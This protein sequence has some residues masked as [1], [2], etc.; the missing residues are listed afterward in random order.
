MT[1][2][3]TLLKNDMRL[4]LKDWKALIL[5]LVM[6]FLFINLF[7]YALSPYL[8]N[9]RFIEPFE[10]ALADNEDTAQTRI[11]ARQLEEIG[12]FK[13]IRRVSEDEA[14][15]LVGKGEVAAAIIIPPEFTH[16]IAVGENKPVTVLGSKAMPL[17]SHVV[18]NLVQSAANLVSAG[19]SAINAIYYYNSKAGLDRKELDREFS[20]STSKFFLEMLSRNEM[21]SHIEG[22]PGFDA[23]PAEYFTAALITVFLMFSGMPAMK[24][25]VNEK[26]MGIIRRLRASS[27]RTWQIVLSKMILSTAVSFFQLVAVIILTLIFLKTYWGSSPGNIILLFSGIIFAVSAWSVFVSSISPTPAAA[28]IVGNLG[29]LLM[30]I[31]GGS[32]YPLSSMPEFIRDLSRF[33]INRWAMEGFMVVFSGN[34]AL[35]IEVY[36]YALIVIGCVLLAA[37]AAVMSLGRRWGRL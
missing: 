14:R 1:V 2:F 16:S 21:F 13:K 8:N 11:L 35:N 37:S 36:I 24:M 5:L 29:I 6:P 12:I 34:N 26:C 18:K 22:M 32:I 4:F 23:T 27:V 9:S 10:I 3:L 17:Q 20:K 19:Q 15:E 7:I 28:D 30:A 31:V 33:T 25:I